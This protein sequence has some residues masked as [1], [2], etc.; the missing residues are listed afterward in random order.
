MPNAS[1]WSRRNNVETSCLSTDSCGSFS[2]QSKAVSAEWF[3]YGHAN[4]KCCFKCF[5]NVPK[6]KDLLSSTDKTFQLLEPSTT[7][8]DLISSGAPAPRGQRGHLPPAL[9]IRGQHGAESDLNT[10]T[11]LSIYC[12]KRVN[13]LATCLLC[14]ICYNLKKVF[15]SLVYYCTEPNHTCKYNSWGCKWLPIASPSYVPLHPLRSSG[16]EL[17]LALRGLRRPCIP[18]SVQWLGTTLPVAYLPLNSRYQSW[19]TRHTRYTNAV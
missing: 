12:L 2:M 16:T 3:P 5:T 6:L 19:W 17:P 7:A 18:Q 1:E 8:K 9:V 13:F 14:G 4:T 11:D 10:T 15:N